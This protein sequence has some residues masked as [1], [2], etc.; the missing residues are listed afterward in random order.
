MAMIKLQ[1]ILSEGTIRLYRGESVH[2]KGGY[3]WATNPEQ[4]RQYTQSGQYKEIL[5]AVMD[6]HKIYKATPLPSWTDDTAVDAAMNYAKDNGFSAFWI[7]ESPEPPSVFVL[8]K[9]ALMKLSRL[10]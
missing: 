10:K 7:S 3:F 6:D 4:A 5:T 8:N 9:T 1:D 2:N